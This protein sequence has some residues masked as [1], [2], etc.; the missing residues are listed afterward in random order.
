MDRDEK[1][2]A[3]IRELVEAY[4][5]QAH[6]P[7]PFT[8]GQTRVNYAGRHYDE[9]ELVAAVEAALDFWLTAGPQAVFIDGQFGFFDISWCG[10][11]V[12]EA[13]TKVTEFFFGHIWV[14]Y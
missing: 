3:Q 12:F 5:R 2:R 14:F 1:L 9:Q 10:Q 8:P 6:A 11:F 4:Y 13:S 7:R